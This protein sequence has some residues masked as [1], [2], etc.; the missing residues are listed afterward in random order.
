MQRAKRLIDEEDDDDDAPA[1]QHNDT[2]S[3]MS[4][5]SETEVRVNG[6]VHAE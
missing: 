5:D 1:D 4:V 2:E 6:V 3:Q